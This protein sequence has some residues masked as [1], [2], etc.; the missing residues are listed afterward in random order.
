MRF[1]GLLGLIAVGLV[2]A[3]A[4]ADE[5]DKLSADKLVGPWVYVSG[6]KDGKKMAD[7]NIK[8]DSVEITKETMTLKAE[9]QE[10]EFVIKYKLDPSKSPCRVSMEITKGPAGEGSKAEGIIE[11][12]DGQLRICYPPM[13]GDAPKDF[14]SKEGSGLHYFVLKK[15]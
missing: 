3:P 9:G 7:E 1:M 11:L 8:K 14:A 2:L 6:V 15:K 10:G 13:G 5:N 4:A 12:K